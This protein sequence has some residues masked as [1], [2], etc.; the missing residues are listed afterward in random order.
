MTK[1]VRGPVG[2]FRDWQAIR[3]WAREIA[4]QLAP[5]DLAKDG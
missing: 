1:V 3:K 4:S 5:N 2:D